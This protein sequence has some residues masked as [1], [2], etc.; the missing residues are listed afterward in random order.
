MYAF[1]EPSTSSFAS[2]T[3]CLIRLR[4]YLDEDMTIEN[5]V[6]KNTAMQD[7]IVKDTTVN[8]LVFYGHEHVRIR[9]IFA[10]SLGT[11]IRFQNFMK[12]SS[13]KVQQ[14]LGKG[15]LDFY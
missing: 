2:N 12:I 6:V 8:K 4:D 11:L 5:T 1:I 14:S 10:L 15:N 3:S 9:P 7:V 13:A